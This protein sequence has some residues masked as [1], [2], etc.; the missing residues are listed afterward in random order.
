MDIGDYYNKIMDSWNMQSMNYLSEYS[1]IIRQNMILDN[2][3]Q[4]RLEKERI[5]YIKNMRENFDRHTFCITEG[6][7]N[8]NEYLDSLSITIPLEKQCLKDDFVVFNIFH[9][10]NSKISNFLALNRF[11]AIADEILGEG[12]RLTQSQDFTSFQKKIAFV[13]RSILPERLPISNEW[14][15]GI[16]D[17][18]S[19]RKYLVEIVANNEGNEFIFKGNTTT[20]YQCL[21]YFSNNKIS[22]KNYVSNKTQGNKKDSNN[23]NSLEL[24]LAELNNLIGLKRVK[25][26]VNTIVNIT[27]MNK[28][29]ESN[30]M[31]QIPMSLHLVFSGNPGTGKTTVARILAE[32][33]RDLGV[34]SKGH[35]IEVD[36]ASLVG[37]YIGQTAIKTTEIINKS[38]G[39]ILFID[40]AYALTP[41]DTSRNDFGI[42][43]VNTILKAMED[44]R[45]DF[46]VIVAGYPD[47]MEKF[48][49]SNPGLE[50]R[51]N[52]FIHF[53][54]YSSEE[55]LVIF[56]NNCKKYKY[57]ITDEAE[58]YLSDYFYTLQNNKNENFANAREVRNL[59]E[60]VIKKQANRLSNNYDMNSE[61]LTTFILEDCII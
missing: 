23:Y 24:S 25:D 59:F 54:D 28:V 33:Y 48:I 15:V 2:I 35:L 4:Q 29:R 39:G 46:I 58:K 16:T 51:F 10:N 56:K 42:E 31:E 61:E 13:A 26:E 53:D 43:A 19:N 52:T 27:K 44:H 47:L 14:I 37:E 49:K 11:W 18:K 7:E 17:C 38:M 1:K 57:K 41:T 5:E 20:V 36:R 21:L 8:I 40:E 9:I 22:S 30:K 34:L 60:K 45:D 12:Y 6:Y 55:M 32:I 3:K 50:S